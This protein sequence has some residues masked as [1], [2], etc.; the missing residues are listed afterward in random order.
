[1]QPVLQCLTGGG[2][3]VQRVK[4]VR[5]IANESSAMISVV[6]PRATR[7]RPALRLFSSSHRSLASSKSKKREELNFNPDVY[8][9]NA[10][11][12][13]HVSYKRLTS[14]DLEVFKHPPTRVKMLVRDYIEDSLYNPHYGYFSKRATIVT[15]PKHIDFATLRDSAEFQEEVAK[16]Y[17]SY[18]KDGPG[19]GKQL[20]H[21]P[22]EIFKVLRGS[23][24]LWCPF[25]YLVCSHGMGR[26]LRGASY[27]NTPSSTSLTK[28]SSFTR[29]ELGT[30]RLPRTSSTTFETLTQKSTNGRGTISWKSAATWPS[31]RSG[32]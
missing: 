16:R 13:E 2:L 32:N 25:L 26:V 28:T 18:G 31:C 27:V 11:N 1:M 30:E 21:T 24:D 19:P 23:D 15:S 17:V 10:P 5:P 22:T 4:S 9:D 29:S 3:G 20:W 7:C 6:A 14:N 8:F 12:P